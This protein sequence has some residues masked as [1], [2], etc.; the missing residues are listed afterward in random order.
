MNITDNFDIQGTLY[1]PQHCV[2]AGG[3]ASNEIW[4]FMGI[5]RTQFKLWKESRAINEL[6]RLV[7]ANWVWPAVRRPFHP[8]AVLK[9][10]VTE[11]R[12][13]E[14]HN[15]LRSDA[16]EI[17]LLYPILRYFAETCC[18]NIGMD[19]EIASLLL[20]CTMLDYMDLMKKGFGTEASATTFR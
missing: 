4:K 7:G 13:D 15:A 10:L 14:K 16:S 18:T 2:Y 12:F 6:H 19:A 8:Q 20:L 5:A 9:T 17:V 1:D 11:K 3:I